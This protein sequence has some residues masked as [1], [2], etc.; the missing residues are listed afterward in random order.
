M[1]TAAIFSFL[2]RVSTRNEPDA[3]WKLLIVT[4][5]SVQATLLVR[6]GSL[7]HVRQFDWTS[8]SIL[9]TDILATQ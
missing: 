1:A 9:A 6:D 5:V 4:V 2:A 7:G 8:T 3:H